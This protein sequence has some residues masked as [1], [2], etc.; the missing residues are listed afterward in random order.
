MKLRNIR[1]QNFRGIKDLEIDIDDTTVL[2]G[3]NNSGKTAILD[4]LR[5]CLRDLASRRRVVFDI[6]DFH[7]KDENADPSSADPIVITITFSEDATGDWD[8][9]LIGLLNRY[10]VLQV[11]GDGRSHVV[12][13]VTCAYDP[14]NRD[15][16]QDWHFLNLNGQP[17][18]GVSEASLSALQREVP[19]FYLPAL[20]DAA[21]HFDAKGPFWKPFLK[22][23]QLSPEKKAEIERKLRE[24]NDLVVASHTTFEQAKDRL[25]TVQEIVPM[26]S[27]E[28]VSIEAVPG[29]IFD[30]LAR[31]QVHLGTYTG[32][33]VPVDRHG[34][35]TQS[36][37]VL[38]LFS[39]FLDA[40]SSGAAIVA[41]EEPEVHLHPC[42]VR[43]LWNVVSG[44]GGQKLVST[45]SG[46]LVSEIPTSALR[47]LVR[48]STGSRVFRLRPGTL[49]PDEERKFNFH[50][51]FARGELLFAK[52]WLLVE[53]ETEV[54]LLT[55][56]AHHLDINL[57]Q[58]GVRCVTYQHAGIELFLKVARDLGISWCVLAD[59]DSQGAADHRHVRSYAG[60]GNLAD[61]LHVMPEDNI[62]RYLCSA[63]FGS[64]YEGCLSRQTKPRVTVAKEDPQYWTQVLE[65]IKNALNKPAA[66]LKVAALICSGTVPVPPLL[67]ETIRAAVALAGGAR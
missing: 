8:A 13:R 9:Q 17:L 47:R 46:D 29:R 52:C 32:A 1:I 6:F 21:W 65:A 35:G 31:A 3:E 30:M 49:T 37:A 40:S 16:Q 4:A 22:D 61:L 41:L 38:M 5:L 55:E 51:R 19:Y 20:R 26:A 24:V 10:R 64:V 27:G 59:N 58:A 15:F 14:A 2:I 33:K 45:H 12:L 39:A 50:I 18:N 56:I 63:G 48:A 53:G 7:L 43:A 67:E 25:R 28:A 44:I 23:S 11:D 42:A 57:E 34:E 36:L 62:E 66:A 54:I 60:G